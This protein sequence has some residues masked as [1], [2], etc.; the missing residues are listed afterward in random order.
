LGRA[1]G[2]RINAVSAAVVDTDALKAFR[3]RG[4]RV[5]NRIEPHRRGGVEYC[6]IMTAVKVP[7]AEAAAGRQAHRPADGSGYLLRDMS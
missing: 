1:R 7:A 3:A 2:V 6:L 5:G 4:T